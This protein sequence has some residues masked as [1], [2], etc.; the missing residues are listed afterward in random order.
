MIWPIPTS[1]AIPP[2]FMFGPFVYR[3]TAFPLQTMG[4]D[5]QVPPTQQ[6]PKPAD[7]PRASL[8]D[9]RTKQYPFHLSSS[10]E[11]PNQSTKP[12][13]RAC[14]NVQLQHHSCPTSPSYL[15]ALAPVDQPNDHRISLILVPCT[16][17]SSLIPTS[18]QNELHWSYVLQGLRSAFFLF[19]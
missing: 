1:F 19:R 17:P 14:A 18:Q 10:A 3:A 16:D 13:A 4:I 12:T 9:S 2:S 15:C 6:S 5:N 8:A 11:R 7:L